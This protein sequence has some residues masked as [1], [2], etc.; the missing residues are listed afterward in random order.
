MSLATKYRPTKFKEVIGQDYTIGVLEAEV[1]SHEVKHA[2]L[3]VGKSGC[4]KSSVSRILANSVDSFTIELDAASNGSVESIRT[5]LNTV[6]T[7]PL[8]HKY[9]VVILDESQALSQAA[10]QTLLKTLE[11]PPKHLIFILCTTE[12]DKIPQPIYNRCEVFEFV[13][14]PTESIVDRL[15]Y[16][17]IK[18]HFDYSPEALEM[19]ARLADGSMR[20][21]ITYLERCSTKSITIETVKEI[22]LADSYDNYLNLIYATLDKEYDKVAQLIQNV[23][24]IDKYLTGLFSFVLDINIY[25]LTKSEKLISTPVCYTDD[26]NRLTKKEFS[27]IKQLRNILLYVQFE[28]RNNP[29]LKQIL[30]AELYKFME[31]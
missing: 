17:C 20:Q 13:F 1:I 27:Q 11:L 24:N 10:V 8:D 12:V 21:A 22:L 23:N 5:L 4:G 15:R 14:I 16:I 25:L 3:F 7:K 19:I 26:F 18:E 2:Y 29:I 30:I 28:G 31:G 9:T 6:K